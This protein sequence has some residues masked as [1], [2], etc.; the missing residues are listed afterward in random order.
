MVVQEEFCAG[1]KRRYAQPAAAERALGND[2]NFLLV[3]V[4]YVDSVPRRGTT[5]STS[6]CV[7]TRV[8]SSKGRSL[9]A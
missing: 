8:M 1:C 5:G 6:S 4:S 3:A 2:S 7:G 9:P